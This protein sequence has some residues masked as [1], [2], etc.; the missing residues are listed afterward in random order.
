MQNRPDMKELIEAVQVFFQGTVAPLLTDP[1]AK[2]Q[3][4]IAN[5][6][7]E[8]LKREIEL[9]E[10][11]SRGEWRSLCKLLG[12]KAGQE[13]LTVR[14]LEAEIL[15]MNG[16]FSRR[17]RAGEFDS[18]PARKAAYDHARAAVT[19]KLKVTNPGYLTEPVP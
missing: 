1:R 13:P 10:G 4:L 9:G 5:N 8:I 6:V 18:G 17:T 19:A 2:F 11:Q 12:E 16:E 15:R 3:G 7:L 14:D